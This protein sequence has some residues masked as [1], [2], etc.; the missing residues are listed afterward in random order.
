MLDRGL[1]A[2][3]PAVLEPLARATERPPVLVAAGVLSVAM[4]VGSLLAIPFFLRR[5]PPDFPRRG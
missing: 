1:E 4:F 5:L 2:V 3:L